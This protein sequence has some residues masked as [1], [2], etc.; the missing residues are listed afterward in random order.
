[1]TVAPPP[2]ARYTKTPAEVYE[3]LLT[4]V[5]GRLRRLA[6]DV[7]R[8]GTPATDLATMRPAHTKAALLAQ[9]TVLTAVSQLGLDE[10]VAQAVR[11]DHPDAD[12]L[13][14]V[15]L[16]K[17]ADALAAEMYDRPSADDHARATELAEATLRAVGLLR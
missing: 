13:P 16:G 2:D 12:K 4:G 11:A 6:D 17:A 3:A 7:Q 15:L 9:R 1:M 10:L 5:A 8:R 14:G